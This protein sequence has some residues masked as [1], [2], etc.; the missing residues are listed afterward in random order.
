M[1]KL[2]DTESAN[3]KRIIQLFEMACG[4][5]R[6]NKEMRLG[7][8]LFLTCYHEDPNIVESMSEENNC[9][10]LDENIY[11]FL[12]EFLIK[13]NERDQKLSNS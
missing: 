10:L 8:A 2:I 5:K 1:E 11:K 13:S 4:V 9:L 7:Q 12:K 6:D 3:L